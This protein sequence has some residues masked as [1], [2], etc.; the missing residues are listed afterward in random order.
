MRNMMWVWWCKQSKSIIKYERKSNL[1]E[2]TRL[3]LKNSYF[4][5]PAE[6]PAGEEMHTSET[7]ERVF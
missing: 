6:G 4:L 7:M 2:S 1:L 5:S 3:Q